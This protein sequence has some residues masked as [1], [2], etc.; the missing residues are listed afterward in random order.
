[1][2]QTKLAQI[3]TEIAA[4]VDIGGNIVGMIVPGQAAYIALG[5]ALAVMAPQ[6]YQD[7]VDLFQSKEPD[8]SDIALLAEDIHA[9][10]NPE[11]A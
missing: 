11:T 6:L 7:A 4:A 2:D 3:Q 1:M 8:A 9:L 5:K 10:L